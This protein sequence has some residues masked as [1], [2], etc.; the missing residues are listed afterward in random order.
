MVIPT[1]IKP[2]IKENKEPLVQIKPIMHR[3]FIYAS[4]YEHNIQNS[5]KKV[6]L[7]EQTA[8][9]LFVALS[10]L[11]AQYS[12]ILYDGFRP[13]QV[14]QF[15]FEQIK[16][17]IRKKNPNWSV[18]EIQ[19]ETLK[20]VA[21][22]SIEDGYPA[23]HLTGGAIDLTIGDADGNPL[24][25]GTAF[26]ETTAQSAT[27]YFESYPQENLIALQNRRLL[28]NSMSLAGFKNYEE[29]WWHYD[30]GNV[31]WARKSGL[32]QAIYG[33]IH[34]T[35]KQNELKEYYFK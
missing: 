26:D 21:F 3:L 5:L 6:Y 22:P 31:T 11:P 34:A 4:Y 15:L 18:E 24:D 35:I 27:A 19:S 7:R 30:F 14:Q 33:P 1:T 8:K 12:F 29:E 28:F 2:I 10:Y 32:K 17:K 9:Q 23:P 20:Y 13:L 16:Q 25:M